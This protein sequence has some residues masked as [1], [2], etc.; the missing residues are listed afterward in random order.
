[1]NISNAQVLVVDDEWTI[2]QQLSRALG[3]VGI[4]CDCAIDGDD[5]LDRCIHHPYD[6]VVTDLRMPERHGHSLAVT[7]LARPDPPLVVALT[8]VTDPRLAKDLL[9]RG[10]ANVVFKPIN[11]FNLA[12]QLKCLLEAAPRRLD[13]EKIRAEKMNASDAA[14][15]QS[16][17]EDTSYQTRR[18]LE[19]QLASAL[20][21]YAWLT[22][23]LQ[24]IDWERLPNPP[25]EIR[26]ALRQLSGCPSHVSSENR[27]EGRAVLNEK[28]VAIALTDDLAPVGQPFK[29]MVRDLS[30]HGIG[31]VHSQHLAGMSLAI[32]W[33]GLRKN[34]IIVL[35]RTLRCRQV[36]PF[37]DIGAMFVRFSNPSHEGL[38]QDPIG[39]E[40]VP[41]PNGPAPVIKA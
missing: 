28:A 3:L 41:E 40:V 1:M 23:A 38:S 9:A 16:K 14:Q 21:P 11:Y 32:S 29:V 39:H 34:R 18:A 25:V 30:H 6:L 24:W 35:I 10:V 4:H 31:I 7:L 19:E 33:R 20:P 12:D 5:A 15:V 2:R 26:D 8:G 22:T 36:G 13:A 27:S 37:Y 17:S